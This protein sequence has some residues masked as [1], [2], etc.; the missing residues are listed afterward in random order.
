MQTESQYI[1]CE[2]ELRLKTAEVE[3]LKVELKDIKEILKLKDEIK[4]RG[5]DEPH[6]G[7]SWKTKTQVNQRR[8]SSMNFQDFTENRTRY[9]VY[10]LWWGI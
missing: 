7:N 10:T 3:I 2:K 8:T 5:L 9:W 6:N 1:Q 4:E